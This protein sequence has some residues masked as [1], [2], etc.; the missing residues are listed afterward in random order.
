[1]SGLPELLVSGEIARLI[2]VIAD[3]RK[4]QRVASVFLATLSAVPDLAQ[5]ILS[6]VGFRPGKRSTIDTYTEVVLDADKKAARDRPDGLIVVTSGKKTWKALLEAKIGKAPLEDEQ[7]QRYLTIARE[8]SIDA[9]ITISNQFA[10]RADHSPVNVSKVL[11]R[12]VSLFHWSWKFILTEAVLLQTRDAVLDPEQAFIL[13]EFIRFLSHD[14]VGITGF[15]SMPA[16]WRDCVGLIRTGGSIRK[17]AP[18]ALVVVSAWHQETRDL[19][20]RMSQHIATDVTVKLPRAHVN[21]AGQR[22]ADDCG[23]LATDHRLEIEYA[24]PNTASPMRLVADLKSQTLRVGM[25]VGAPLDRQRGTARVTWLLRQLKA[26]E[27]SGIYVRIIWPSR[28]KDTV[29]P[30]TSLREDPKE[31]LGNTSLA[32]K[33]FEVF[34]LGDDARRFAGRK[35]FI[36]DIETLVPRFYDQVGQ[37]LQ[38]WQPRPPKPIKAKEPGTK[39]ATAEAQAVTAVKQVPPPSSTKSTEMTPGNQH[40]ALLELPAFLRRTGDET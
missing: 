11:T 29:L 20:L 7:V 10:A 35:T 31:A 37:H 32:P 40:S 33:G 2:P 14:S 19:A 5:S 36:E 1:M 12:R 21:D 3:S 25:E 39:T 30:L 16:E 34:L 27:D 15:D 38:Q 23:L 8:H 24:I 28:T 22:L 4:E 6:S 26:A 13:R 17:T 18:E 9:V